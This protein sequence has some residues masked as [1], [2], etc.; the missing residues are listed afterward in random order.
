MKGYNVSSFFEKSETKDLINR[1]LYEKN[2]HKALDIPLK[3]EKSTEEIKKFLPKTFK[4]DKHENQ[5]KYFI[6]CNDAI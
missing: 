5:K 6:E 4:K 2:K 3:C 1:N